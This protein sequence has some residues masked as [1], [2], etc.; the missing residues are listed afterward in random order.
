MEVDDVH[1]EVITDYTAY[2]LL[3]KV[4]TQRAAVYKVNFNE[5]LVLAKQDIQKGRSDINKGAMI[6]EPYDWENVYA[7]NVY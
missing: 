2:K 5:W 4:D 1:M 3:S 6:R 7:Y